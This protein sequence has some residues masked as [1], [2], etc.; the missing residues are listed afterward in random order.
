MFPGSAEELFW[1]FDVKFNNLKV[2]LYL[3][4]CGMLLC[5]LQKG[6]GPPA[7]EPV[8]SE[9]EQKQMMAYYYKKQEEFK[10]HPDILLYLRLH[11]I[12]LLLHLISSLAD[13]KGHRTESI[14]KNPSIIE[15]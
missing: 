11:L 10:V 3:V 2:E 1:F 13:S 9:D 7:R 15:Q 8:V 12:R 4:T 6:G 14:F 5:V